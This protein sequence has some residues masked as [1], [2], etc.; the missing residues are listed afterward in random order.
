MKIICTALL[1]L[2]VSAQ[3]TVYN[4]ADDILPLCAVEICFEIQ[5][6]NGREKVQPQDCTCEPISCDIS[7]R[8]CTVTTWETDNS[9]WLD[10]LRWF[11]MNSL[12][13]GY[14]ALVSQ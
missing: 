5:T 1:I 4:P 12:T 11:L 3:M 10:D 13:L 7:S 8:K 14:Y 2:S 6:P 9:V